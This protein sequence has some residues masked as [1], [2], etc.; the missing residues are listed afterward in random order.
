MCALAPTAGAAAHQGAEEWAKANAKPL[1]ERW[2]TSGILDGR[3]PQILTDA[4]HMLLEHLPD[5]PRNTAFAEIFSG[6]GATAHAVSDIFGV[7]ALT[8]D[9]KDN[10]F[11]Q[12]LCSF[13]AGIQL[14][15]SRPIH[16]T[17]PKTQ[18]PQKHNFEFRCP[19]LL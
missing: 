2:G 4:V 15:S 3:G 18:Q 8:Y 14:D 6:R 7:T 9:R 10:R 12:D 17:G 11:T 13:V 1:V 16:K 5:I 19:S